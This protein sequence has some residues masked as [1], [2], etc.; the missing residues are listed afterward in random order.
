MVVCPEL[1][2]VVVVVVAGATVVVVV[3]SSLPTKELKKEESCCDSSCELISSTSANSSIKAS[4][5]PS[6]SRSSIS[7][8][9]EAMTLAKVL[10]SCV[11]FSALNVS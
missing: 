3:V 11:A 2:V 9:W 7:L 6:D 4:S 10:L 5:A 1:E 8:I